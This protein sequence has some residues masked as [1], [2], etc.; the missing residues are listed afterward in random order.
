LRLDQREADTT[1][2][3]KMMEWRRVLE[4]TLCQGAGLIT[5]LTAL[6]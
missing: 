1:P 3:A 6:D 2:F 5:V 4:A